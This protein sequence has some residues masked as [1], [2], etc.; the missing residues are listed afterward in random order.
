MCS[1]DNMQITQ[2]TFYILAQ[3]KKKTISKGHKKQWNTI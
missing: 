1:I 3:K 2:F